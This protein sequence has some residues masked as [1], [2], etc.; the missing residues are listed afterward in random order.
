MFAARNMMFASPVAAGADPLEGIALSLRL[1][2]HNGDN[3][4]IGLYTDT[5]CTTPAT[6]AG[7][8][9]AAWKDELGTSG[10]VF[11]Q[12]TSGNR[13]T[14]QFDS[15]VPVV[16]FNGT[17]QYLDYSSANIS[18]DRRTAVVGYKASNATGGNIMQFRLSGYGY[19]LRHFESG[20]A[21]I[22]GDIL[23]TNQTIPALPSAHNWHTATWYQDASRNT[24]YRLNGIEETVSGNPP[25]A[26]SGTTGATIGRIFV[27]PSTIVQ[28]FPGDITTIIVADGQLSPGDIE[29]IE[30]YC[31]DLNP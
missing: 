11:T 10:I 3:S 30:T 7:D 9:I 31:T 5:A 17:D 24:S 16:R 15:G 6:T 28:L 14:L 19:L 2:T 8:L 26:E 23:T 22:G 18:V 12:A 21:Y 13:P 29:T 25:N 4:P 27:P 1:Q 20:V